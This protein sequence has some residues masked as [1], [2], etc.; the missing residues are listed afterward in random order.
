[1]ALHEAFYGLRADCANRASVYAR[2]AVDAGIRADSP[3]VAGLRNSVHRAGI[4]TCAAV[5]AFVR[6]SMS[7]S[8]HLPFCIRFYVLISE[9]LAYRT[10]K[11][12]HKAAEI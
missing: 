12:H 4:V 11:V 5:D 2:A 9:K 1:M 8:I 3:F 10:K 7:Q 6:N